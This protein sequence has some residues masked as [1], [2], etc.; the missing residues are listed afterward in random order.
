VSVSVQQ[1]QLMALAVGVVSVSLQQ[2]E[3]M[4]FVLS[5]GWLSGSAVAV[6]PNMHCHDSCSYDS[7]EQ[8]MLRAAS[9][10]MGGWSDLCRLCK[11]CVVKVHQRCA[12]CSVCDCC[13]GCADVFA[14]CQCSDRR[15]EGGCCV[16]YLPLLRPYNRL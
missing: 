15:A 8:S 6:S 4:A 10:R 9:W 14:V 5:V 12:S 11:P 3:L 2:Q 7:V 13:C 16:S 1:Q